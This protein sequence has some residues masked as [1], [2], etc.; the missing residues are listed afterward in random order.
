MIS[1]PFFADFF[2]RTR[3][4]SFIVF[5]NN[6]IVGGCFCVAVYNAFFLYE[7]CSAQFHLIMKVWALS[8]EEIPL[9]GL[10]C[11]TLFLA[12]GLAQFFFTALKLK[13]ISAIVLQILSIYKH[14]RRTCC[15]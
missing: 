8:Q 11:D 10:L 15:S 4:L 6:M 5:G 1:F 3:E 14:L 9:K 13:P 7:F 12:V 2:K